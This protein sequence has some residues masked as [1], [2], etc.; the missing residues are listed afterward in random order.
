MQWHKIDENKINKIEGLISIFQDLDSDSPFYDSLHFLSNLN[1]LKEANSH[2][3]SELL[4][5]NLDLPNNDSTAS[6]VHD[7]ESAAHA[8]SLLAGAEEHTNDETWE[9][10]FT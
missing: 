3:I 1:D 6:P 10:D 4:I 2:K 5:K 7:S 9:Y 8:E